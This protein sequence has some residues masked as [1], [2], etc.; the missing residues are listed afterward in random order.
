MTTLDA[1][2]D[3][4]LREGLHY[5]YSAAQQRV[6]LFGMTI[7]DQDIREVDV[8]FRELDLTQEQVTELVVEHAWRV[9]WVMS[10]WNYSV[11]NRIKMALIFL[12][13]REPKA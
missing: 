5:D 11:I 12:F 13:A 10:P 6:S 8:R 9:R 3:N 2:L 1:I 7:R 4:P